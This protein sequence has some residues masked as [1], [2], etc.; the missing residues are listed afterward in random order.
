MEKKPLRKWRSVK[1]NLI[2]MDQSMPVMDGNEATRKILR[3]AGDEPPVII[4]VT[5]NAMNEFRDAAL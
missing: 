5:G 4:S 3:E 2:L 1:P